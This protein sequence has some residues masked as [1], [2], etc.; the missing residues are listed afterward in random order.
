MYDENMIIG[1]TITREISNFQS[2]I[3]LYLFAFS[4]AK[5][6]PIDGMEYGIEYQM[7]PGSLSSWVFQSV[8]LPREVERITTPIPP[9]SSRN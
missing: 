9:T 2:P 6:L 5:L 7:V 1:R 4:L 3:S 8:I